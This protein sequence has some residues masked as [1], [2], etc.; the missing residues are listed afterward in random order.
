MRGVH[1]N[2]KADRRALNLILKEAEWRNEESLAKSFVEQAL[3]QG[4]M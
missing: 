3:L 2:D 1:V 4:A